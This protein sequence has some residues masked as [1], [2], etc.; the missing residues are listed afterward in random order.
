[1]TGRCLACRERVDGLDGPSI[2]D[3]CEA[4][5]TPD[6]APVPVGEREPEPGD[7]VRVPVD[8]LGEI[9]G[10]VLH[11]DG[12]TVVVVSRDDG[13]ERRWPLAVLRERDA[14]VVPR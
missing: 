13:V 4:R 2:C 1:M 14:V 5:A 3:D 10:D 11:R 8:G 7:R 6:D 9:A 12:D